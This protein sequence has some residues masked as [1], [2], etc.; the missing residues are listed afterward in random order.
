MDMATM[1][2]RSRAFQ[3]VSFFWN[4]LVQIDQVSLYEHDHEY[5]TYDELWNKICSVVEGRV[6]VGVGSD[7]K[8]Q[9]DLRSVDSEEDYAGCK[10]GQESAT[11]AYGNADGL[12]FLEQSRKTKCSECQ[13]IVE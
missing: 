3:C 4:L 10:V 7:T 8:S 6:H 9:V 11:D 1:L 2:R 5:E 12:T 13:R